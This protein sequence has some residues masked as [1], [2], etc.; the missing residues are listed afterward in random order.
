MFSDLIPFSSHGNPR[1]EGCFQ[2]RT[3]MF[4]EDVGLAKVGAPPVRGTA[5]TDCLWV[6]ST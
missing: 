1:R 6:L 2:A 4:Q 3:L 5:V